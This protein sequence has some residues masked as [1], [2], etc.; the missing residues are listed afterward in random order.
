[1]IR[2][3]PRYFITV[4]GHALRGALENKPRKLCLCQLPDFCAGICPL[5]ACKLL[6]PEISSIEFRPV[7][8]KI[9]LHQFRLSTHKVLN[10]KWINP[11]D[12]NAK[13]SYAYV[14]VVCI[15]KSGSTSLGYVIW[16]TLH[17]HL[18]T[19]F[20]N[21]WSSDIPGEL[22]TSTNQ[23]VLNTSG[24]ITLGSRRNQLN[25]CQT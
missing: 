17:D 8:G 2:S 22:E 11:A 3:Y 18:E 13:D 24:A 20:E 9:V 5:I 16:L 19:S 12:C 14:H 15:M 10:F 7:A 21:S 25:H 1:M 23:E 6:H 4:R